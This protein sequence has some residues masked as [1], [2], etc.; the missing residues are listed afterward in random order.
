MPHVEVNGVRLLVQESGSGEP[1]VLVHGS[2]DDRTV[3]GPV[4][5]ALSNRFHVVTYDRRGHSGGDDHTGNGTR[6]DDEDDLADLI[7]SLRLSP[8]NV[9]GNSFGASI[10][11]GLAARRPEL[12]RALCV[13]EPPLVSLVADDPSVVGAAQ[14]IEGVLDLIQRGD[15]EA[16]AH[17]FVDHVALGPGAWEQLSPDERTL[18]ITNAPT[19]RGEQAD[20][21]W[22]QLDLSA[23]SGITFPVLLTHGDQSPPFFATIVARLA[24]ALDRAEVQTLAGAGH[25]PHVTNRA[26]YVATVTGFL[27]R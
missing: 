7:E 8:A 27:T 18:M 2:W 6:R 13:H 26:D 11:L 20:P 14:A 16:A 23:L 4:A 17:T 25:I 22:A 24:A 9:A 10:A 1:V 5:D 21:G 19:F 3:W 15:T 12:F